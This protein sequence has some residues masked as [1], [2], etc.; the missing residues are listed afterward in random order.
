[1]L[2]VDPRFQ[3]GYLRG[4]YEPWV[5]DL[6]R[7]HLRPGDVYFD[8]GAHI[9][10]FVLCAATIVGEYGRIVALEP[11]PQNFSI[12]AANIQRNGLQCV[13]AIKAA[14]W[15]SSGE[16]TFASPASTSGRLQGRVTSDDSFTE[17]GAAG[18]RKVAALRLDDISSSPPTVVKIDVEGAEIEACRGAG[19]L[20]VEKKTVWIVEAH[21][22]AQAT[23]LDE[24]F[25]QCGYDVTATFPR[26]PAYGQYREK[27]IVAKPRRP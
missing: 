8:I 15:S 5:Q 4:D 9:G 26:H 27:Y 10:F 20:L 2:S 13:T 19:R 18:D 6:L 23:K 25:N 21:G 16:V 22:A 14:A 12:L 3:V 24:L 1:M 11:D 17:E 7:T